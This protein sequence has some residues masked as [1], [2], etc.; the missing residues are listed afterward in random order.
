MARTSVRDLYDARLAAEEAGGDFASE[1]RRLG[2]M[3]ARMH[4]ALAEAF[5]RRDEPVAQV[6]SAVG[7]H[8][9][10][11]APSMLERP[12][13]PEMLASLASSKDTCAIV[14]AHGDF[15]LGRVWRAEQGWM[16]VELTAGE[17]PV[18]RPGGVP[19]DADLDAD[20]GPGPIER[21]PLG[22][23]ADMIW[24]LRH[25]RRRGRSPARPAGPRG[26][27]VRS[28]PTGWRG[29]VQPSCPATSA[30]P[31]IS[32]LI[33]ADP[34]HCGMLL[35]IFELDRL[36]GRIGRTTE[37]GGPEPEWPGGLMRIGILTGGGDCPGA[38]RRDTRRR[39]HRRTYTW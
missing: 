15:H 19:S 11:I 36:A 7:S 6:S 27:S 14:R 22:D 25:R 18:N 33:P 24:S 39:A 2:T 4:L 26:T 31:G 38:E 13:L 35:T 34:R 20:V 17:H 23:A 12:D 28:P 8:I 10:E 5:G 30:V 21:S 37:P 9:A 32:G 3:T 1:A 29:T 16:V